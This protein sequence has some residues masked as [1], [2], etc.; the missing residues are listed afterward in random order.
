M[1]DTARTFETPE[2][3]DLQLHVAG[4]V[5]RSLAWAI[6]M[7]IRGV[8]Y[9][10]LSIVLSILGEFGQGILL[11]CI[12]LLEW[13]YPVFF[14]VLKNGATPGKKKM[15][16]RVV[17][18]NGTPVSWSTS[19]TRNLL[20]TADF[21]PAFYGFGLTAMLMNSDFKRLGDMAAGT[22]VIYSSKVAAKSDIPK[23]E[24][25]PLPINLSIKEQRAILDFAERSELLSAE[26]R[27]ELANIVPALTN[28]ED[29]QAVNTLYRY[30]NWLYG[31][32]AQ[33]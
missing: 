22:M 19:V 9:V 1:L 3:V 32:T 18:D 33:K 27:E 13:F 5:V 10:V 2:G 15:G 26:R 11:L 25:A 12:F 17:N 30:A 20:R 28:S 14:E 16:I 23:A 7:L 4:P 21:A 8:I 6:D 29:Q 24:P 31:K